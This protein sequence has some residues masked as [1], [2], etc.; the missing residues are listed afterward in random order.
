MSLYF[1][2]V[3]W[4]FF[5]DSVQYSCT[6]QCFLQGPKL[7]CSAFLVHLSWCCW[8]R[9][10]ICRGTRENINSLRDP[11]ST[12]KAETDGNWL[13]VHLLLSSFNVYQFPHPLFQGAVTLASP[14]SGEE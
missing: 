8:R 13:L 3:V 9:R 12:Q 6:A 7:A 11:A 4:V 1:F 5:G 2:G 10:S 14:Q